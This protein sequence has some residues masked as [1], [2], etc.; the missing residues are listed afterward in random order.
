MNGAFDI[1]E[2]VARLT[3]GRPLLIV[4]ADEVLLR[5]VDGF[6]KFLRER[7]LFLDL[8]SY[9]LHGNVKRLD[10]QSAILDVE[11][12]ALLDDFR[13]ELDSLEIVEGAV[14]TLDSLK[15]K[16]DIVVLTN[17]HPSQAQHRVRNFSRLGLDLPLVAN[18]GLK[19]P[20]VK[21]LAAGA[22]RPAFFVDDIPQNL[23][24]AAEIVPDIFRIHLI[25]D[26][27]LKPLLP[28]AEHAHL[29]AD[30]WRHA[31]RFIEEKLSEAGL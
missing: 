22:G 12:T 30:D 2:A 5:F 26:D 6:D 21:A 31:G 4:D 15:T 19:G 10:D 7:Q 3:P 11:V 29:R 23:Q 25:G 28:A 18:S 20:A 27:R 1:G 17:I 14:A 24:S 9:R 16:L 13:R 8:V